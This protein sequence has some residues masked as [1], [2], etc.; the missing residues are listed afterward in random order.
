MIIMGLQRINRVKYPFYNDSSYLFSGA[1]S[2][3]DSS[4]FRGEDIFNTIF[5]KFSSARNPF[6]SFHEMNEVDTDAETQIRLSFL[7]AALG[8]NKRVRYQRQVNCSTCSG[9]GAERGHPPTVCSA[10]KG[11][12]FEKRARSGFIFSQPCNTCAGTGSI[13]THPCTKC[14]GA[15]TTTTYEEVELNIPPGILLSFIELNSY[16]LRGN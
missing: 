14:R 5:S 1:G 12:G 8:C 4:A 10:C 2:G 7:E 15:K 3:F 11:T 9:T 13:N 6:S 16:L